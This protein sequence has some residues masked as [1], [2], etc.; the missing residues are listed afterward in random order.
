MQ[1][2]TT[3]QL[4]QVR[5]L[6]KDKKISLAE[7][8]QGLD[9]GTVARMLDTLRTWVAIQVSDTTKPAPPYEGW[10]LVED[11]TAPVGTIE[12]EL[13]EFLREGEEFVKGE[14]MRERSKQLGFVLGER[15]ARALLKRQ[16]RIPEAW[17]QYYLVFPGTVWRDHD[18]FLGV[19]Y[20]RWYGGQWDLGFRW[21]GGDFCRSGRVVAPRK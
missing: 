20:L 8:Q 3:A 15:H 17:R 7:F 10:E 6:A 11:S 14:V 2:V 16:D 1:A 9:N 19:P 18:G 13:N 21:I 5:K 4:E 12:L